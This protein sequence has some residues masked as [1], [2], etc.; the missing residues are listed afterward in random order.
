M[1]RMWLAAVL[2]MTFTW[3]LPAAAWAQDK[4]IELKFSTGSVPFTAI[5]PA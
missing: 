5:T 1:R 4:P 3:L 2:A